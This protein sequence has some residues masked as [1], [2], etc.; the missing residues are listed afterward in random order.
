M[1]GSGDRLR[2]KAADSGDRLLMADFKDWRRKRIM[3]SEWPRS[4]ARVLENAKEEKEKIAR[5]EGASSED[6]AAERDRVAGYEVLKITMAERSKFSRPE[7]QFLENAMVERGRN[8]LDRS[9][10]DHRCGFQ[11][12]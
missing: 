12:L 10:Q 11:R 3:R 9:R 8:S 6:H 1:A 7:A 4:E 2:R 5:Y